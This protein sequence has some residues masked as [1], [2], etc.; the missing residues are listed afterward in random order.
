MKLM[1]GLLTERLSRNQIKSKHL[2][3]SPFPHSKFTQN[4]P[5]SQIQSN[6]NHL[7][8]AKQPMN[9]RTEVK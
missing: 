5:G 6:S 8:T 1:D 9:L 3:Q 2:S 4:S 7:A